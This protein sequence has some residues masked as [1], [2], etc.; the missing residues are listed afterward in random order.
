M[1]IFVITLLSLTALFAAG[2][3]SNRRAPGF[4]LPDMRGIQHDPQDYRGKVVI[5]DFM[6]TTCPHCQKLSEILEQAKAKYKDKIEV[7][8]I[9]T[10]PDTFANVQKYIS[11]RKITSPILFDSGQ[12]MASY[13]KITPQNPSVSF[14]H[15]FLIDTKGII[16]NDF[17]YNSATAPVFEGEALFPEIDKLLAAK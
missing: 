8:S 3:F 15:L 9:V 2:E 12:V 6:Q 13:L 11:E 16:K 14:P 17:A 1:R 5:V 4:S 7:L 10:M